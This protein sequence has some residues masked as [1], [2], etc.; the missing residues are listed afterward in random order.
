MVGD[1][2]LFDVF[3]G[4]TTETSAPVSMRNVFLV[5][6][7]EIRMRLTSSVVIPDA[8]VFRFVFAV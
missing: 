3:D 2:I 1:G 8:S 4:G 6:E 5:V 7:S